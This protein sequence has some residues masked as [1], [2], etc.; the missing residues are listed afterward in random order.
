MLIPS[1]CGMTQTSSNGRT[2]F[3]L[4]LELWIWIG[5]RFDQPNLIIPDSTFD[6]KKEFERWDQSNHMNMLVMEQAIPKIFQ[7]T[8]FDEITIVRDFIHSL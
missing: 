7:G 2:M 1:Q 3:N 6:E 4:C 8:M 5:L